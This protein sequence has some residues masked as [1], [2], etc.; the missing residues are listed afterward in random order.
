MLD[1]NLHNLDIKISPLSEHVKFIINW[2]GGRNVFTLKI[3]DLR[4]AKISKEKQ[5]E[6]GT[7]ELVK[8][9][10][11]IERL[12]KIQTLLRYKRT[13]I[14]FH[15]IWK[16]SSVGQMIGSSQFGTIKSLHFE[17]RTSN[18]NQILPSQASIKYVNDT[19]FYI[20]KG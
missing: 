18:L 12:E 3:D 10:L 4:S 8:F 13:E 5:L 16:E 17:L 6:M 7:L 11:F 14:N 1:T 2:S 19:F 9:I 20:D 15:R